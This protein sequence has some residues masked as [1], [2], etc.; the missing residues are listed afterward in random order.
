MINL[1]QLSKKVPTKLVRFGITGLG[2]TLIHVATATSLIEFMSTS[3]Q[4]GNGVA[5]VVATFFSYTVNTLWSFSNKMDKGNA[6]RFLVASFIGL[7]LT[8]AISSIAD[9]LGFHYLIGISVI[10]ITVPICTFLIHNF[11]TY[12]H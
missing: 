5:F 12:K 10:V 3:V 1:L 9:N 2:S 6:F 7:S 4:I 11:W 8:L